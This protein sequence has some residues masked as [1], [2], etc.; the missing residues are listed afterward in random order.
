[1]RLLLTEISSNLACK[2]ICYAHKSVL[3]DSRRTRR[4]SRDA[5]SCALRVRTAGVRPLF[6]GSRQDRWGSLRLYCGGIAYAASCCSKFS[7]LKTRTG[8]SEGETP[9]GFSRTQVDQDRKGSV[10]RSPNMKWLDSL[11]RWEMKNI[12]PQSDHLKPAQ[13]VL[14]STTVLNISLNQP[15]GGS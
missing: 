10:R 2:L 6:A 8:L 1:M 5:R 7:I 15:R 12:D 4:S 11:M 9:S 13:Q 14:I 3:T